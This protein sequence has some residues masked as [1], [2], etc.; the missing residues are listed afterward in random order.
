M[1]ARVIA[2]QPAI[3]RENRS[4]P[5]APSSS[6]ASISRSGPDAFFPFA[7]SGSLWRAYRGAL[8][9]RPLPLILRYR[10]TE[11]G[12][13]LPYRPRRH[14]R[15]RIG[16]RIPPAGSEMRA[17]AIAA[18]V[19]AAFVGVM[20]LRFASDSVPGPPPGA[21]VGGTQCV[22]FRNVP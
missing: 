3:A 19:V 15:S 17:A 5:I 21:A 20:Y 16:L 7:P 22:V 6:P 4:F 12:T 14:L 2:R 18:A 13:T 10:R 1:R 11:R 9:A 8:L